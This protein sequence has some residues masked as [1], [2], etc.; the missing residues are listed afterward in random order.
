MGQTKPTA[1]PQSPLDARAI[2]LS[3]LSTFSK[4]LELGDVDGVVSTFLP[5]G[6]LRDI[7][8]FTWNNRT[9]KGHTAMRAFLAPSLQATQITKVVLDERQYLHPVYGPIGPHVDG[10]STGFTFETRIAKGQGYARLAEDEKST[11]R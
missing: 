10:V 5:N 7:L 2:A 3:W 8:V 11:L 6:Y 9:S 1:I 4:A